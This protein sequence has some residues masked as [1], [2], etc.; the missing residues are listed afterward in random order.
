MQHN[1]G[2]RT[3]HGE[4]VEKLQKRLKELRNVSPKR[5]IKVNTIT[6]NACNR[7]YLW[8]A[9]S[10][11][12]YSQRRRTARVLDAPTS[13]P[14]QKPSL[15]GGSRRQLSA[16]RPTKLRRLNAA[17][18]APR[19]LHSATG[20]PVSRLYFFVILGGAWTYANFCH[21]QHSPVIMP[22]LPRHQSI[23]LTINMWKIQQRM[24][25]VAASKVI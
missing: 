12:F 2:M 7:D 19:P 5:D 4:A 13:T 14:C 24:V 8:T 16:S 21:L 22:P 17:T 20:V 3:Q 18:S 9:L 25:V 6:V 15:P 11:A 1:L 23:H 10:C